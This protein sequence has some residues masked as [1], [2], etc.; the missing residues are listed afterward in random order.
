M[1]SQIFKFDEQ[2]LV[3]IQPGE[4]K[5]LCKVNLDSVLGSVGTQLNPEW[6]RAAAW[7]LLRSCEECCSSF[8]EIETL[9]GRRYS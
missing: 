5:K 8:K 1:P 4:E 3:T 6:R 7:R 9:I 2:Q